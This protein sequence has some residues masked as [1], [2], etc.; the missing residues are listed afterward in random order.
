[1]SEK[2]EITPAQHVQTIKGLLEQRKDTLRAVLPKHVPPERIIK[3]ALTG[4]VRQPLLMQCTTTSIIKGVMEAA[5]LG[6]DCSGVLGSAYLV[7]H[8]TKVKGPNGQERYE[9]QAV[10]I[11]GYRGLIDL[12]RRS[13]QIKS[14]VAH[15]VYE[16]DEFECTFGLEEAL[17]HRPNF[18]AERSDDK[19]IAAYMVAQLEG[20]GTQV[21]VMTRGEIDRVRTR[22]RAAQSGPWVSD[23]AEMARK[24]VVRRGAKYLP[25]SVEMAEALAAE[26]RVEGIGEGVILDIPEPE[27]EVP[28][29]V[30]EA[31]PPEP[32]PGPE[33]TQ[34]QAKKLADKI[35]GGDK[36]FPEQA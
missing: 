10:F 3:L 27:I 18:K 36:L 22:S 16:G 1:M 8:R 30:V 4:I 34:A 32:E 11:P 35:K 14:I 15:V 17:V 25:L 29:E 20:G 19:I 5:Q 2:K 12:A 13:G 31:A 28:G 9:M 6:L 24:T 26:E 21:E 7:P 33:P 23:F